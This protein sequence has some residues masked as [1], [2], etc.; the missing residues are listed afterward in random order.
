M[1]FENRQEALAVPANHSAR[2][3]DDKG[4]FPARPEPE[5]R[6]PEGTIER[7]EFGLRSRLGVRCELLAQGKLDDR[8]L[9]A[10]SEEGESAAKKC[11]DEA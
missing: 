3:D 2:L 8:L 10:A 5:E 9:V 6:N 11:R 7:C 4:V 1:N